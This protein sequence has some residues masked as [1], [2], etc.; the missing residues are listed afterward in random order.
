MNRNCKHKIEKV[1]NKCLILINKLMYN[2][3][4]RLFYMKMKVSQAK[5]VPCHRA[6]CHVD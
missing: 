2:D 1:V 5:E 3:V 6:I 4:S